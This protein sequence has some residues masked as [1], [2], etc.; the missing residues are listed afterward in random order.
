VLQLR[1]VLKMNITFHASDELHSGG[2]GVGVRGV[3]VNNVERCLAQQVQSLKLRWTR[4]G[5]ICLKSIL[6]LFGVDF[7]FV[8]SLFVIVV[9]AVCSLLSALATSGGAWSGREILFF[10]FMIELLG[11][12]F[13]ET[14]ERTSARSGGVLSVFGSDLPHSYHLYICM[15]KYG[16]CP[17]R[18]IAIF[19]YCTL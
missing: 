19:S 12:F 18:V 9:C 17:L 15:Y 2:G 13:V 3:R 6:Y 10:I 16:N 14:F 5:C 7:V 4:F 11:M 1:V 8:L